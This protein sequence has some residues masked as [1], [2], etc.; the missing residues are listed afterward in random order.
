MTLWKH[1]R[2]TDVAVEVLKRFWIKEKA[3]WSFRVR[4]WNIGPHEPYCMNIEQ[5][6]KIDGE[7]WRRDWRPWESDKKSDKKCDLFV[8]E[9]PRNC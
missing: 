4:W 5:R 1:V 2:N 7:I 9:L 8:T 3:A 6:L